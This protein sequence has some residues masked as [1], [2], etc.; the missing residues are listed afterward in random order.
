MAAS[1]NFTDRHGVAFNVALISR[2]SCLHPGMRYKARGLN[3]LAGPGNECEVDQLVWK[4]SAPGE[5]RNQARR[6]AAGAK[7]VLGGCAEG[8]WMRWGGVSAPGTT[9]WSVHT[10]RRGT[11]PIWWGAEMKN[12]G[13]G[14]VDVNVKAVTPYLGTKQ[15]AVRQHT[16]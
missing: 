2:R 5:F 6:C 8:W 4:C 14:D 15:C 1:S 9:E 13:F 10:W 16:Y 11:V 7:S 3:A 12:G